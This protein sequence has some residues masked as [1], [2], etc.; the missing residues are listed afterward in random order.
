MP[1]FQWTPKKARWQALG[2]GSCHLAQG[3]F[4]SCVLG[5]KFFKS[6]CACLY[7]GENGETQTLQNG[8]LSMP[9]WCGLYPVLVERNHMH[10]HYLP[11]LLFSRSFLSDSLQPHGLQHTRLPCPSPSPSICSN[12]TSIESVMPSNH[13]VGDAIQPSHPQSPPLPLPSNS[14]SIRLFPTE[15][16]LRIRW[17]VY[18]SVSFSVSPSS[19]YSGL[20]SFRMDWFD[21]AVQGTPDVGSS[22]RSLAWSLP[23]AWLTGPCIPAA[24]LAADLAIRLPA[25][26]WA[27]PPWHPPSWWQKAVGP[28]AAQC[29]LLPRA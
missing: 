5:A 25:W 9:C 1:S 11:A 13:W 16:A 26:V 10:G 17:P 24:L 29:L 15:L 8:R 18:W 6:R 3:S 22:S 20:I 12:S 4:L 14:P 28:A 23:T 21:L 19:D 27:S 2:H 7:N